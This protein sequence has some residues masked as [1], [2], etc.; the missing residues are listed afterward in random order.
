MHVRSIVAITYERWIYQNNHQRPRTHQ[1]SISV[2]TLWSSDEFRTYTG[3]PQPES[4]MSFV[5]AG[6]YGNHTSL[7]VVRFCTSVRW[8]QREVVIL[9]A[10]ESVVGKG[11]VSP[12][13]LF[14]GVELR[15]FFPCCLTFKIMIF[16]SPHLS[17]SN[18]CNHNLRHR[19][20]RTSVNKSLLFGWIFFSP[21]GWMFSY[22]VWSQMVDF[23]ES[24]FQ[25]RNRNEA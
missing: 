6:V 18:L 25:V 19:L 8:C 10:K 11:H 23:T 3:T 20:K 17:L 1:F 13:M 5:F 2:R 12:S 9:I 24:I 22:M 16:L 14:E 4:T 15:S 21:W 7:H